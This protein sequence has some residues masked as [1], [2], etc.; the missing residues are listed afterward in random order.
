M[1]SFARRK[2]LGRSR[3]AV[4]HCTAR[5][6]RRAWL[7][8]K[9][10]LTNEDYTHRRR[11]INIREE[12]LAALFAI[13]LEYTAEMRNHLH[14]VLR[15]RPEI[16]QKLSDREV[17]RRWLTITRLAKC[18]SDD[19]P[20][21]QEARIEKMLE[22]KE[23]VRELRQRLSSISWFMAILLENIA[24]RA[25]HD[26]EVTGH[27]WEAR[28]RC[29]EVT[30]KAG[31]LLCGVYVDLNAIRAGEANSLETSVYTSVFKRIMSEQLAEDDPTRPD[32]Y[33]AAL[34]LKPER[35]ADWE[36]A[37]KSRTG[38]RASDLG[39]IPISLANYVKLLEWTAQLLLS[40]QRT[41]IPK[42]L[43]AVLDHMN[44]DSEKWVDAVQDYEKFGHAVGSP[45]GL[46][47]VAERMGRQHIKGAAAS[48]RLYNS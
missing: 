18:M 43:G 27:F 36:W 32:G 16:A 45:A 11:W 46:V 13:E 20:V 44:V 24:R 33:L 34:T 6:V 2:L 5:C 12:Q 48:R 28:F 22:D 41:T 21:P 23:H 29:R 8:G 10:P 31:I 35:K 3:K 30:D 25:N 26:D 39:V 38:R 4:F 37:Y 15:T 17:V 47:E 19:L 7:C 14:V 1:A 40:G 9:D 42:D